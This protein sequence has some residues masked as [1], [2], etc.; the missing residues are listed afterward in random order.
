M[1]EVDDFLG[2]LADG[3]ESERVP[4]FFAEVMEDGVDFVSIDSWVFKWK[5]TL[6]DEV[7]A[8]LGPRRKIEFILAFPGGQ[9]GCSLLW[10]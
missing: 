6:R 8:H 7:F 2:F 3:S 10:W 9:Q 4:R 1:V 5:D